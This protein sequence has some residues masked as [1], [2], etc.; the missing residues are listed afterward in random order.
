MF[1]IFCPQCNKR[2][3]VGTRRIVRFENTADG[4]VAQVKCLQGHL[5]TTDFGR[6]PKKTASTPATD[7]PAPTKPAEEDEVAA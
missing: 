5:V 7:A 1:S 4:P 2:H 6:N 3:L